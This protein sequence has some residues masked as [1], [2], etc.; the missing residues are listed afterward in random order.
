[1]NSE[2]YTNHTIWKHLSDANAALDTFSEE[3]R[4]NWQY[5]ETRERL[6]YLQ[7][8]LDQS[9]KSLVTS[10]ELD[11]LANQMTQ[12]AN[13]IGNNIDRPARLAQTDQWFAQIVEKLPYPRVRKIFRSE[14]TEILNDFEQRVFSLDEFAQRRLNE[15]KTKHRE[16]ESAIAA[17]NESLEKVQVVPRGVV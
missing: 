11:F 8:V 9:D 1:M 14:R 5:S 3:L 6:D 13:H 10:G 2:D 7:W 12:I 15:A 17:A 4:H 16:L